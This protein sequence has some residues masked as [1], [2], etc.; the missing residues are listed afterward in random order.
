VLLSE[1][2]L[3]PAVKGAKD[4]AKLEPIGGQLQRTGFLAVQQI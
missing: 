1:E 2:D 3:Q 4:E